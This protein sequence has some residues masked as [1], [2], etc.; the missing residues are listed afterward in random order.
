VKAMA[1]IHNQRALLDN[2]TGRYMKQLYP[3]DRED[4]KRFVEE[5]LA[6]G[7]SPA[8]VMKYM[9]T[10]GSIKKRLGTPFKDATIEDGPKS[11][12]RGAEL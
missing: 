11:Q 1:D 9:Y 2:M 12:L 7:Y 8:R 5:L 4:V 3:R 10:F 6:Q